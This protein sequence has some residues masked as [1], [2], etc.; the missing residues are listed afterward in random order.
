[1]SLVGEGAL[2]DARDCSPGA[3]SSISQGWSVQPRRS[4][5]QW[6]KEL[7]YVLFS[8][9]HPF[10]R[11][12]IHP[13]SSIYKLPIRVI[14]HVLLLNLCSKGCSCADSSFPAITPKV[15]PS[16]QLRILLAVPENSLMRFPK[17]SDS[18]TPI[19]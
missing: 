7:P 12:I 11:T 16:L 19:G 9:E 5:Q 4:P 1:M 10:D 15:F 13:I 14:A 3:S 2:S 17:P 6:V 8:R 18:T